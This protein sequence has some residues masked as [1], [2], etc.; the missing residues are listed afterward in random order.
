MRIG[1]CVHSGVH[2]RG[3]TVAGG[4][5]QL[6]G[7]QAADPDQRDSGDPVSLK[8]KSL[9]S[10]TPVAQSRRFTLA[11]GNHRAI[12]IAEEALLGSGTFLPFS[13]ILPKIILP[14]AVCRTL[15]TE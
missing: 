15:V 11:D 1:R 9:K 4:H 8:T 10:K 6:H 13:S 7:Y 3:W 14:L 2:A 5:P 12:S